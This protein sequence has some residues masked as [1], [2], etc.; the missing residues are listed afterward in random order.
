MLSRIDGVRIAMASLIE[1]PL[2]TV[3]TLLGIAIGVT[4]VILVVSIIQGLDHYVARTIGN[5]GP[6]VFVVSRFEIS[7]DPQY[8]ERA[9]RRNPRLTM[10]DAEAIRRRATSIDKLGVTQQNNRAVRAGSQTLNDINIRGVTLEIPEIEELDLS[11]GRLFVSAEHRGAARRVILGDEVASKLF[12]N[13]DP[14]GQRVQVFNRSFTVT[15]VAK[16]KGSSFGQSQ[17]A[18]V[19]IPLETFQKIRGPRG[20]IN[21]TIKV[22]DPTGLDKA[23]DDVRGILRSRQHTD[24][25]EEDK[26]GIITSAGVMTFWRNLTEMIFN[27][28]IFVVSISL[29]VGGIVI[30]NIMLLT[31][32]ERTREIGIRKA[33]GAR[34]GDIEFQFMVESVLLCALGGC[35]GVLVAWLLVF[36]INWLTPLP[37]SFPLWAPLMAVGLTSAVG[38]FFGIHP[39]KSAGRLDP[40][41]ALRRM[42]V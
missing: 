23:I 10:A 6:S 30:M 37:A 36:L 31:V 20:R 12:P 28:A 4:A 35:C 27:V 1:N 40:I 24:F 17:D 5:L 34:Q 15:G 22:P 26:F 2:R 7:T 8:F 21:F 19:I 32:V 39:A 14:L 25:Q 42:P 33:I 13:S 9:W 11:A 29:V 41:D 38:I 18:F 16:R 3:L